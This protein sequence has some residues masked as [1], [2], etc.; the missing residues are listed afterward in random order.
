MC[1]I[2]P[3]C[4]SLQSGICPKSSLIF[5]VLD[6]F[7]EY[8]AYTLK[9]DP[10]P[11]SIWCF[12]YDQVQVALLG[13]IPQ[14]TT[15]A[16]LYVLCIAGHTQPL[17]EILNYIVW[18]CCSLG[19][20]YC[21]SSFS[22]LISILWGII[23]IKLYQCLFLHQTTTHTDNTIVDNHHDDDFPGPSFLLHL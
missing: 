21:E 1:R 8:M 16:V 13:R 2:N 9:V 11:G 14:N 6:S 15:D 3:A 7:I 10:Q 20:L 22:P 17:L 12:F 5:C 19:F 18:S 4:H 23:P